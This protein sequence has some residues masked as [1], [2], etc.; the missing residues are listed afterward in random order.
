MKPEHR[1]ILLTIQ[2]EKTMSKMYPEKWTFS[3]ERKLAVAIGTNRAVVHELFCILKFLNLCES[4]LRNGTYM[5]HLQNSKFEKFLVRYGVHEFSD[6][7]KSVINLEIESV[8]Q[9]KEKLDRVKTRN[10]CDDVVKELKVIIE[11]LFEKLT[12]I[13]NNRTDTVVVPE[14]IE[15]SG[16]DL[17][18]TVNK[19]FSCE[20]TKCDLVDLINEIIEKVKENVF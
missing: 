17:D 20:K 19:F 16:N 5:S 1:K 15:D 3:P 10:E 7:E 11:R 13:Y 12:K 4:L 14:F 9:E 2:K 8:L 6:D 18:E